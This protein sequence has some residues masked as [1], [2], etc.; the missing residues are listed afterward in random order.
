MLTPD[1]VPSCAQLKVIEIIP[2][3][4][5][6]EPA[7][8]DH[9]P[10]LCSRVF[11]RKILIVDSATGSGKSRVLPSAFARELRGCLLVITPSTVDV[12]GMQRHAA[13][14]CRASYRMG[15]GRH[16]DRAWRDTDV[17]FT[18]CGLAF[19]WYA[20][21]GASY[22]FGWPVTGVLFDEIDRMEGDPNYALLWEAARATQENHPDF[23]I[24][25][26]SATFT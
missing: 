12:V 14:T 13:E 10:E 16:H 6:R 5:R 4:S 23:F 3:R 26:A 8:L 19:Q 20:E 24:G 2:G 1:D 17:M 9:L 18:T 11:L 15:Q 7:L 25:G 21:R 22:L